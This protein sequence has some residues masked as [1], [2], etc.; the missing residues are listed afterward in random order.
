MADAV[1]QPLPN[2][3]QVTVPINS[4]RDANGVSWEGIGVTPDLWVKNERADVEA[5]RD[6]VLGTALAFLRAGA[7]RPWDRSAQQ[8]A[9]PSHTE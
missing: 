3:W 9:A 1:P 2:G 4:F 5:G 8:P 6:R 7:L